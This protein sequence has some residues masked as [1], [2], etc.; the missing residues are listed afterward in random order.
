MG[1]IENN[2]QPTGIDQ[3]P[4]EIYQQTLKDIIKENF[5]SPI[6]ECKVVIN[7]ASAKGDNYIGVMY[8]ANIK[9]PKGKELNVIIKLPPPNAARREQFSA[10]PCFVR[11]SEFYDEIYP[12]FKKFQ[13]DKG[14]DVEKDGF[15]EVPSCYKSLT[16]EPLEALYLEDLKVTGFEMFDR[17]KDITVD[18]VNLAMKSIGKLH[19]LSFAM[20]DQKPDLIAPY[21]EM[22]DIFIERDEK[23]KENIRTWF[24]MLKK[25]AVDCFKE[26]TRENVKEK[27]HEILKSDFFEIL[28]SCINSEAA[29]PYAV[30]CH[31]DCWNNNMMYRYEVTIN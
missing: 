23:A 12:M 21:K 19:A 30:I 1:Q 17:F 18:H 5:D 29:G 10:R 24:E 27:A 7:A 8:R 31:G 25:Q 3:L 4:C 28:E 2:E 20:K 22:K 16:E 13:E 26:G 9:D 14:I 6:E 11:E 15:Y